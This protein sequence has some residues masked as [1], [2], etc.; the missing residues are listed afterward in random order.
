MR[1]WQPTPV[2]LPREFH[3]QRS[4]VDYSLK[5]LEVTK[6]TEHEHKPDVYIYEDIEHSSLGYTVGP[7]CLSIICNL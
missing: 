4:L 5:E 2:S 7:C 3:G 1:A 6:V